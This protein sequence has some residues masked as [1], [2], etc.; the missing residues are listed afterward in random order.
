MTHSEEIDSRTI[1]CFDRH[2]DQGDAFYELLSKLG[3]VRIVNDLQE[4]LDRLKDGSIT[5]GLLDTGSLIDSPTGLHSYLHEFRGKLPLGLMTELPLEKYISELRYWGLLQCIG[6]DSRQLDYE[7]EHFLQ[8]LEEPLSGFGLLS[9]LGS[10]IEMYSLD[11]TTIEEKNQAIERV[12]N[13]F[14]TCGF[15]VHELYDVRLILEELTNNALFHAFRNASGEEKYSISNFKR[16]DEMESVRLEY[17]SDNKA[18]GFSVTD[19]AGSLPIDIILSK[20]ERQLTQEGIFDSSGR[21]LHLSQLLASRLVF[22]VER[23]RRT[24]IV[25]MFDEQ[26]KSDHVRPLTINFVGEDEFELWSEDEDFD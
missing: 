8:M 9:Y 25:A 16:L 13:H 23:N 20:I 7:I 3:N 1:L 14:A 26:R 21:G 11:I 24:Q 17:G 10:T 18:V 5:H 2:G 19:S 22:N 4:F 15:E 12:I 6:K